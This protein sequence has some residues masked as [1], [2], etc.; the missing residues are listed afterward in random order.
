[1]ESSEFDPLEKY[2]KPAGYGNPPFPH[3]DYVEQGRLPWKYGPAGSAIVLPN[4]LASYPRVCAHRGFHNIAP[5]NSI[6]AFGAAVAL[7]TDEIEFN[8]W[9]TKDGKIVSRHDCSL[10]RVS[11]GFERSTRHLSLNK[12]T[13]LQR[14]VFRFRSLPA[15]QYMR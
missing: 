10:E 3:R 1:M 9:I 5:E 2:R 6:P 8:L 15:G 11:T 14:A 7:G 4:R 13:A 12:K